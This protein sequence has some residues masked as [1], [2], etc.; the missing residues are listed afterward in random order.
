MRYAR[1]KGTGVHTGSTS[2]VQTGSVSISEAHTAFTEVHTRFVSRVKDRAEEGSFNLGHPG[3]S[4]R[5]PEVGGWKISLG[6]HVTESY[7]IN[8][9]EK[10]TR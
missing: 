6:R 7:I 2:E 5:R 4:D 1:T 10:G 8:G 9:T 3:G